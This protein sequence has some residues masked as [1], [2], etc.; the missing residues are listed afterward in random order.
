MFGQ[1]SVSVSR[2]DAPKLHQVGISSDLFL[3]QAQRARLSSSCSASFSWKRK[4]SCILNVAQDVRQSILD[5]PP[6]RLPPSSL[7]KTV[8]ADHIL[9]RDFA[10][11][12][13]TGSNFEP[14]LFISHLA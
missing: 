1:D 11:I 2:M 7:S 12:L 5:R 9:R 6:K 8:N 10:V 4:R 13:D 3:K 14:R